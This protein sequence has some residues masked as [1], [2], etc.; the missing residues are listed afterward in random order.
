MLAVRVVDFAVL[1]HATQFFT[2]GYWRLSWS[3]F[4]ET[5]QHQDV[6]LQ[7]RQPSSRSIP[8]S[9]FLHLPLILHLALRFG[10]VGSGPGND[11]VVAQ[12]ICAVVAALII[13]LLEESL[14]SAEAESRGVGRNGLRD[15]FSEL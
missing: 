1:Q 11:V 4:I 12:I 7:P 3:I 8:T 10:N 2:S 9:A 13:C 6:S 15:P 14:L 5:G